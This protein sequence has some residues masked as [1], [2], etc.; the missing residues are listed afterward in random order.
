MTSDPIEFLKETVPA[1]LNEPL[2]E[3]KAAA[4]KGDAEAKKKIEEAQ[5]S[6]PLAVR[7]VLE[8]KSKRD[9][10][11][12]WDKGKL[13]TVEGSTSAPVLFAIAVS[14]EAFEVALGDLEADLEKGLAKL[15]KRI[16]Q[17]QPARARAGIERAAQEKLTFHYVVKDTPDF[18]EVRVKVAIGGKEPPEKPGFTVTLDYDVFEQL[19]ARK[20][21]PQAL[22]SKLQ[23]TGPDSARAM[24]LMMQ[25]AQRRAG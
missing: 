25:L 24:Q 17:L 23:L 10:Y 2:A 6:A 16:P 14:A 3:V 12:V 5:A 11:V 7:V 15:R 13:E 9:L 22:L 1:V 18:D 20:L 19:R 4:D 8:G 21:K